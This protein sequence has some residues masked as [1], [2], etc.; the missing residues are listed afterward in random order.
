MGFEPGR[1][2][3]PLNQSQPTRDLVP[4][5]EGLVHH[6]SLRSVWLALPVLHAC[7]GSLR[8]PRALPDPGQVHQLHPVDSKRPKIGTRPGVGTGRARATF[9]RAGS[10]ADRPPLRCF[11]GGGTRYQAQ[12]CCPG[13]ACMAHTDARP[14]VR[15]T[16]HRCVRSVG[17]QISRSQGVRDRSPTQPTIREGVRATPVGTPQGALMS[18][19]ER[20]IVPEPRVGLRREEPGA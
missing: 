2:R 14:G 5:P 13:R 8:P 17:R 16:R 18:L 10:A 7:H 12:T 19:S 15:R 9:G 20:A 4:T 1:K 6:P 11:R 3:E